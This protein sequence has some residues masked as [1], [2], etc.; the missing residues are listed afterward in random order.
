MKC[1]HSTEVSVIIFAKNISTFSAFFDKN[2]TIDFKFPDIIQCIN[3]C[4]N[5][6]SILIEI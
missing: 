2:V 6:L 5:I 4:R 3:V 1:T